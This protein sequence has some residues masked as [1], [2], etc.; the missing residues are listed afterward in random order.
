MIYVISISQRVNLILKDILLFK[1]Y[2]KKHYELN[3][4]SAVSKSHDPV[5]P[6]AHSGYTDLGKSPFMS[7]KVQQ[8]DQ[9][10]IC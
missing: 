7:S 3:H 1:M 4:Y 2:E 10:Q 5:H 9:Y 6:P 8:D